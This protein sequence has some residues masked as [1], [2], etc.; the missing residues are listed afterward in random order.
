MEQSSAS[1]TVTVW[2]A[3]KVL[4][5]TMS[6]YE[7]TPISRLRALCQEFQDGVLVARAFLDL[8]AALQRALR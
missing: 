1:T 5:D 3:R 4:E 8:G 2:D 7:K 6:Y